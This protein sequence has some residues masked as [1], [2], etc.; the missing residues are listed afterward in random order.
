MVEP[1]AI[2]PRRIAVIQTAFLGD[3]IFTSP[4]VQVLKAAWPNAKLTLVT[5]PRNASAALCIPGVDAVVPFDKHGA[6][7]GLRG[8]KRVAKLLGPQDLALAPHPS[9]RSAML[10]WMTRAPVRVGNDATLK[11]RFFTQK[12]VVREREPFVQ[13]SMDLARALGIEGPTELVLVPP[14]SEV[15]RARLALEGPPAV[16]LIIGS[17]WATKRWPAESFAALADRVDEVGLRPVLFGAPSERPLA[18]AVLGAV[19]R[20]RP[21]DAVGNDLLESLAMLSILE[22]VVGGDTGLSHAARAL[23]TPTLLLFGPT[24]PGAH[25]L[26]H[27]AQALRVGLDCQPCDLH[28]PRKCPLGQQ[29]CMRTLEVER[30][31]SSLTSLISRGGR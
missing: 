19:R 26:E 24:D 25:T 21:V 20:A 29:D 15:V 28:G 5:R 13:Q 11:R 3:V 7:G 31:F 1:L 8:L 30:V 6:D 17:S 23:G 10:A 16:G 18:D 4:L 12:V 2:D 14:P 22:G 9:L 27:H